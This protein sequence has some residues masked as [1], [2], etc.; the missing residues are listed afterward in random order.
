MPPQVI[1]GHLNG[2]TSFPSN[3]KDITTCKT[4]NEKEL[5]TMKLKDLAQKCN[6]V[7]SGPPSSVCKDNSVVANNR[8]VEKKEDKS[9]HV[10]AQSLEKVKDLMAS[11]A[12]QS[13]KINHLEQ[14]IASMDQNL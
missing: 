12:L 14:K 10:I 2:A 4:F 5:I 7:A 3:T 6:L 9:Y 11:K 8:T 1:G 13:D